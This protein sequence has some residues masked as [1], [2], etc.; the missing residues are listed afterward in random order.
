M[1]FFES[2]SLLPSDQS[3]LR[4]GKSTGTLMLSALNDWTTALEQGIDVEV[5]YFDFTKAFDKVPLDKVA[6]KFMEIAHSLE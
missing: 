4:M 3:D 5:I 2:N 1:S 6:V